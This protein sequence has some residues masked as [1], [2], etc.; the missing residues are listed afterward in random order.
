ML[1][2]KE[3]FNKLFELI[4]AFEKRA[5]FAIVLLLITSTVIPIYEFKYFNDQLEQ[6]KIENKNNS[7]ACELRTKI[8][9]E[10]L[11]AKEK[12][13]NEIFKYYSQKF[14]TM[15]NDVNITINQKIKDK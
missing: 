15:Y 1:S 10:K 12:E 14:E 7:I 6:C 5:Q 9:S 3:L 2:I 13:I 8:L 11:E 4:G